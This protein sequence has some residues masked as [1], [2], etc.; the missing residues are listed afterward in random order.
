MASVLVR[1]EHFAILHERFSR[2][3]VNSLLPMLLPD[4]SGYRIMIFGSSG[5]ETLFLSA[6]GNEPDGQDQD[7][8]GEQ[9]QSYGST[10]PPGSSL[11]VV[12]RDP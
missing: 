4:V 11:N 2:R 5:E 7:G 8:A 1:V 6:T 9:N 3:N 12:L 10:Q